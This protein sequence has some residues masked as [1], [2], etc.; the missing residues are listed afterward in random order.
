MNS[1]EKI[2]DLLSTL[3]VAS[4]SRYIGKNNLYHINESRFS[5]EAT[6]LSEILLI[7]RGFNVFKDKTLRLE[8]LAGLGKTDL[9]SIMLADNYTVE[10]LKKFN[11]FSWGNNNKSIQMLVQY[12]SI[13]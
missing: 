6:F 2:T 9:S 4:L 11:N 5:I 12:I 3:G 7:E 8:L 10:D 13:Y 1:L